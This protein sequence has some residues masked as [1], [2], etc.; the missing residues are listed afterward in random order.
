MNSFWKA[1]WRQS[2]EA[3][4]IVSRVTWATWFLAG[5]ALFSGCSGGE[6]ISRYQAPKVETKLAAAGD[7]RMLSAMAL[8]DNT[9]WFFKMTG[10]EEAVQK[11][12]QPFESLVRSLRFEEG[13]PK[14]DLPSGWKQEAGSAIRFATIR[15]PADRQ[16]LELTVIPLPVPGADTEEYI[17]SNV[18]RW[19]GQLQLPEISSAELE[20][21]A[22][23]FEVNGD[24]VVLVNLKGKLSGGGMGQ[25]P[26]AGGGAP[27]A[28]GGAPFASGEAIAASPGSDSSGGAG[29][30]ASGAAGGPSAAGD[31]KYEKPA[32]WK[33]A[34]GN[35][36]SR[37]AFEVVEGDKRVEITLSSAGGDLLANVNR[38][39]DQAQAPH[40]TQE[41]LKKAIKPIKLANGSPG[42]Y[43]T[44]VGPQQ[45]ILGVVANASG[46]TWFVKLRGDKDLAAKEQANFESFVRSLTLP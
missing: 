43:V 11:Q 44:I 30:A 42:D 19:R 2:P 17:L 12:A 36:F 7:D 25:A 35:A 23:R 5:L 20:K 41:S 34:A 37:A 9:A 4:V 29:P 32:S 16:L 28:G 14:W 46:R 15:V 1:P 24:L 39:C 26:F 33:A 10:P 38:W 21:Q 18:N 40:F 3:R 6:E 27:F 45:T 22:K 8:H 31:P 13:Q